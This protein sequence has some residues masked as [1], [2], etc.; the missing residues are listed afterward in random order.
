MPQTGTLTVTISIGGIAFSGKAS[1][2]GEGSIGQVVTLPAGKAGAISASGVDGLTTGHGIIGTDIIDIHWDDPSDGSHKCRRKVTVDSAAA[3]AI[4]FDNSPAA[5]GDT[6]PAE[7]TAV[8]IAKQVTISQGF[9]AN[10]LQ[11]IGAVATERAVLDFRS[12]GAS[13]LA[14]KLV[15]KEGWAWA[16]NQGVAN[17]MSGDTIAT[18]VASNG[19]T[20]AATLTVTGLLDTVA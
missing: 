7:D 3:N 19:S 14:Q 11:L 2:T 5:E 4:T 6:L 1:R 12:S 16:I 17:P 8:V 9:I 20:T 10:Q 15:S 18:M 13:E